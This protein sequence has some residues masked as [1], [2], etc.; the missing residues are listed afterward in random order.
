MLTLCRGY[1]TINN[2]DNWPVNYREIS[3]YHTIVPAIASRGTPNAKR[4]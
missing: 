4:R 3:Q 1:V 2:T